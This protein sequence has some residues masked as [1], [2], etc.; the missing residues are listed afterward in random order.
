MGDFRGI[1]VNLIFPLR[2]DFLALVLSW[3]D[4][5]DPISLMSNGW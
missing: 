4:A 3:S 2:D 1:W 5:I